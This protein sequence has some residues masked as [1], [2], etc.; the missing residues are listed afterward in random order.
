[1]IGGTILTTL[2]PTFCLHTSFSE[3]LQTL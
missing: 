2:H 1:V 3:T